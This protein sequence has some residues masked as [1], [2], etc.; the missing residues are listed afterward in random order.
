MKK[1]L[2]RVLLAA[3]MV[4]LL[5]S[6]GSNSNPNSSNTSG[7]QPA[8]GSSVSKPVSSGNYKDTVVI[9]VSQSCQTPDAQMA[10]DVGGKIITKM[11]HMPLIF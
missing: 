10:T 1:I 7:Q 9:G 3:I 8:D 11:I 6:C 4:N 2:A 5:T